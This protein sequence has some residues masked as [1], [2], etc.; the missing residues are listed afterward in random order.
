M[1][2]SRKNLLDVINEKMEKEKEESL[3]KDDEEN[4]PAEKEPDG[5]DDD[6]DENKEKD[7]VD[8]DDEKDSE[9]DEDEDEN[10]KNKMKTESTDLITLIKSFE[11]LPTIDESELNNKVNLLFEGNDFSSEFKEKTKLLIETTVNSLV[12]E[13][14]E[15]F[16]KVGE[17]YLNEQTILIEQK[18]TE[19]IDQ[20]L[21]EMA[22]EW[23]EENKIAI[24]NGLVLEQA[25]SFMSGLRELFLEHNINV[26]S[27][28]EDVVVEQKNTILELK[29]ML[30]EEIEAKNN[31]KREMLKLRK[32]QEYDNLTSGLSLTEKEKVRKLT[33]SLT[34]TNFDKFSNKLK[35]IVE[36]VANKGTEIIN[37][38]KD[39][40]LTE[41]VKDKKTTDDIVQK[42]VD[43]LKRNRS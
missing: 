25:Q 33:E 18:L 12:E 42:T 41:S 10:D 5:D 7:S 15:A 35:L 32:A 24:E 21:T 19:D 4:D 3:E 30:N 36:S 22:N 9:D 23:L 31:L 38:N 6:E 34:E 14:F 1:P 13:K 40:L 16:C 17:Q 27:E 11:S 28:Y 37:N 20:Y 43:L 39:K 26:P 2:R 8:D 29:E